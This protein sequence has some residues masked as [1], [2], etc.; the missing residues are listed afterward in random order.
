MKKI[1][2][3]F[4]ALILVCCT[5]SM[6]AAVSE[7]LK[8]GTGDVGFPELG[9]RFTPPEAYR[10]TKGIIVMEGP[11]DL[12]KTVDVVFCTYLA[13]TEEE[14]AE[15]RAASGTVVVAENPYWIN[16]VFSVFTVRKGMTFSEYNN[17][18][19]KRYTSAQVERAREIGK[20]GD[21]TYYLLMDDPDRD[22]PMPSDPAFLD[23][24][25]ALA[26]AEDEVA[27]GFSFQEAEAAP[28]PYAG[29]KGSKIVFTAKDLEGNE[30]SSADL[31][32]Q[33]KVTLLNIG[34]TWCGACITELKD[35]QAIHEKMGEKGA[36]VI[37]ILT[38]DNLDLAREE[39]AENGVQYPI[40]LAPDNLA[41]IIQVKA[42][43]TSLFVG[44]DGTVLAEPV[45]GALVSRYHTIL[46]E[47]LRK[48][49]D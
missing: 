48:Q 43:P 47:L 10:D 38:D 22:F 40:I 23:E 21:T 36:G 19:G 4:L 15:F 29:L 24:Y 7:V 25:R 27:A 41:D 31:F 13:M 1:I 8:G 17:Y 30:V 39:I 6:A 3:L 46:N 18:S 28:D 42:Y 9:F 14:Y 2:S 44:Q 49:G 16:D 34:A 5:V 32:A 37:G 11:F 26:R 20:V 45:V 12:S 35:L 33:N